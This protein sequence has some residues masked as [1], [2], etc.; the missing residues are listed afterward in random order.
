MPMNDTWPYP[1][2]APVTR[3]RRVAHAY[4]AKLQT[5]DPASCREVDKQM[6]GY[7]QNWVA[8]RLLA[9]G[10]DDWLSVAEACEIASILPATLRIWRS[11]N[12]IV[13]RVKGGKWH[14]L[15]RDVLALAAEPRERKPT[16]DV[17]TVLS[18]DLEPYRAKHTE[19]E[20]VDAD[21]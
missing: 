15:A 6:F 3:A 5:V 18:D 4:R 10:L 11:R 16:V 2:D 19:E 13:G 9:Y 17:D 1:G 21:Q 14:Y 20:T 8:P 12:R 7:G